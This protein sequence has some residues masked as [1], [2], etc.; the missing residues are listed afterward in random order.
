VTVKCTTCAHIFR[1]KRKSLIVTLPVR[2]GDERALEASAPSELPP[3]PPSREWK[4]RQPSGRQL[5]CREL[6]TLQKW[7]I[8][9][10]VG[11]EDEI[12]LTGDTWK[13]LG[14]IPELASF[15]L[16]VDEA[17]KARTLEAIHGATPVPM[18]PMP[19]PVS[20]S[21]PP[22]LP[23]QAR[24]SGLS[25]RITETWREP[26]FTLPFTGTK[27]VETM[28]AVQQ[29]LLGPPPPPPPSQPSP[30]RPTPKKRDTAKQFPPL[31]PADDTL[32][33]SDT[34]PTRLYEPSESQL[35]AAVGSGRS[36]AGKWVGLLALLAAVGA[37][38][39][40]FGVYSA[41]HP[42]TPPGGEAPLETRTL[43]PPVDPVPP[44][45][46]DAG[47]DAGFDAGL[48]AGL[49]DAGFDAGLP[50]AGPPDAGSAPALEAP[51]A[52]RPAVAAA[53][54]TFE[55]ILAQAT[56]LRERDK[57]EAAMNLY[58]LAHE[59]RPDSVE[60]LAGRGLTLLDLGNPAVAEASFEQALKVNPRYTP[61][62][63]GMAEALRLQGKKAQA[64]EFYQRYLDVLP[65]GSESAVARSN[66]ERLKE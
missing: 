2:P 41:E 37:G 42:R 1:V 23:M 22:P 4:V 39:W 58:G 3:P 61:A 30:P 5:V 63:M 29:Q 16:I 52:G 56:A 47:E 48:D 46:V 38:G 31:P 50:D 10:K 64:V 12:S 19:M 21:M 66:I 26:D 13:R 53:P 11:R 35:R 17:A 32:P 36:G 45:A 59:L 7:I 33:P 62:I 15:F 20:M 28:P 8:E 6:T 44:A 24:P 34:E 14:E 55:G 18:S 60:P 51:D 57:P 43:P 27:T 49:P 9:N 65:D 25:P 54:R 40:Y